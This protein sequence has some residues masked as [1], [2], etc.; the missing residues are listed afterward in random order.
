MHNLWWKVNM[1]N[2]QLVQACTQTM[3]MGLGG[4]VVRVLRLQSQDC[5]FDPLHQD[6]ILGKDGNLDC[7][8]L[9]KGV[10]RVAGL[11][12]GSF[13]HYVWLQLRYLP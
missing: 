10:K 5:G 8:F 13:L 4:S 3:H 12:I 7:A 9:H 1:G 2:Q 11:R 6:N